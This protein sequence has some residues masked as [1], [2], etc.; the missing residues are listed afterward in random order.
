MA[1]LHSVEM[2]EDSDYTSPNMWAMPSYHPDFNGIPEPIHSPTL[3]KIA[4]VFKMRLYKD[5]LE[6]RD[7]RRHNNEDEWLRHKIHNQV[8]LKV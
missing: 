3:R 7:H 4:F 1:I 2:R 5:P 6:E 8:E